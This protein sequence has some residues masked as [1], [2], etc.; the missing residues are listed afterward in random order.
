MATLCVSEIG[1]KHK[2]WMADMKRKIEITLVVALIVIGAVL[3]LTTG[4]GH[5]RNE[6][7]LVPGNEITIRN[8]TNGLVHYWIKPYN[9]PGKPE[10]KALKVDKI[11]RYP[12]RVAM[13]ISYKRVDGDVTYNLQPGTP[14]SFRYD[15]KNLIQLYEGA[16]GREDAVDLAP[17]VPTPMPVVEK[18]LEMA[19]VSS[20]DVVYD[21]GCGDGRVVIT[22]AK[23]Y[24]AHGVGIDIVPQR[25]KESKEGAKKAGVEKL[26]EFRLGDVMKMDFSKATVVTLYLLPESNE[27]LR[28]LLER[29]LKPGI[30]VVS[31]NYH[32]PG[33]EEK[34]VNSVEL[35]DENGK[36]HTIFLYKR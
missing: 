6:L 25:I 18:M 15:N 11:H 1:L 29:Q 10:E 26:V 2:D 22:S 31:H 34:E 17:F 7:S 36:S 35:D 3:L 23:K 5:K 33:W 9:S 24:G 30:Y 28:P 32:I 14:Y 13:E 21:L 16:H 27:L 8:V 19:Q 12:S 20:S 4:T